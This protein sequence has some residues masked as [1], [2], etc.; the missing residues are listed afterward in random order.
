MRLEGKVALITG[1]GTGIGAAIAEKFVQEGAKIVI[2]GR[3]KELLEKVA[4]AMCR[5]SKT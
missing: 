5:T 3:R 2:T 1:G 4:P